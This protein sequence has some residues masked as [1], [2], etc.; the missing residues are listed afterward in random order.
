MISKRND[1]NELTYKTERDSQTQKMN[2]RLPGGRE[3]QKVMYSLLY[4]KWVTNKNLLYSTWKST[5]CYVPAWI[6]WGY[7]GE[8]IHIYVWLSPFVI[9]LK[10]PQHC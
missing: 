9:Q 1:T 7:A 2:L 6:G 10:L 8:W 4:S 5:Q 3:F